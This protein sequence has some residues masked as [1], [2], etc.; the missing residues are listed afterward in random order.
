MH[1]TVKEFREFLNNLPENI[2]EC[3]RK[4]FDLLKEN[5]SHPSLHFKKVG[6]CW[7]VRVGEKY[8]AIAIKTGDDFR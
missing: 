5:P 2:Q 3:A 6:G 1:F 7:S 8:R 4:N